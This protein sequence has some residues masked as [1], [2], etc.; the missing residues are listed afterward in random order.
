MADV[1]AFD[2]GPQSGI[3]MD[4]VVDKIMEAAQIAKGIKEL[5]DMLS[6]QKS[7][8]HNL[9]S[10]V[11]PDVF[12]EAGVSEF[13]TDDGTKVK[14]SDI[15]SGTLPKDPDK[16]SVAIKHLTEI[17]GEAI[18]KNTLTAQFEKSEHNAAVAIFEDLKK[19]GYTVDLVDGVH[20]QTLLSFIRE[21]LKNGEPIDLSALGCYAARMAKITL[22]KN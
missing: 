18:I 14:I 6:E 4:A 9:R 19:E 1:D 3:A 15:V 17:G 22:P 13:T 12:A 16:R 7:R 2:E 8:L 11:L 5:E 21:K 10:I 20:P